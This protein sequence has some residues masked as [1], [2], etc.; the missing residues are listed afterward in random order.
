MK[1]ILSESDYG[2]HIEL[3]PE[4]LKEVSQLVRFARNAKKKPADIY[5]SFSKYTKNEEPYLS[6][7]M[8]KVNRLVQHDSIKP[9]LK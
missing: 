8:D 6:I 4:T 2:I 5:M 7:N 9:G 3:N 1:V